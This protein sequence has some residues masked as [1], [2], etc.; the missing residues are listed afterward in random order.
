MKKLAIALVV[1][2]VLYVAADLVV[3]NMARTALQSEATKRAPEATTVETRLEGFPFLLTALTTGK[4][5][6]VGATFRQVDVGGLGFDSIDVEVDGPVAD[7]AVLLRERRMELV[8]I[9]KATVS[10]E[11]T[12]AA[13]TKLLGVPVHFAPGAATV[14]VAGRSVTAT[15]V[16]RGRTIVFGARGAS[17][18]PVPLPRQDLLPCSPAVQVMAGRLRLSCSFTEIPPALVQAVSQAA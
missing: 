15:V 7:R 17:L 5:R 6:A 4:V 3:L 1:L 18:A 2:V 11:V 8:A 10:A 14:D 16:T 9:D 13:V 12:D